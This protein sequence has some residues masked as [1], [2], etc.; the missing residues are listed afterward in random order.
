MKLSVLMVVT[1][2]VL[3]SSAHAQDAR[4]A[5]RPDLVKF[6]QSQMEQRD[7]QAVKACLIKNIDK[8]S[9]GCRIRIKEALAKRQMK[10]S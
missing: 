1:G 4:T 8:L 5:C 10:A 7:R 6:C 3:A 9:D 2:L